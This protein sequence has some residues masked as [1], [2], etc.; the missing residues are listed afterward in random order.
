MSSRMNKSTRDVVVILTVKQSQ[1]TKCLPVLPL[2]IGDG[3]LTQNDG[4]SLVFKETIPSHVTPPTQ[5]EVTEKIFKV[6]NEKLSLL[7]QSKAKK[8]LAFG[9]VPSNTDLKDSR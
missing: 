8:P 6:L 5:A 9:P 2:Q 4:E 1:L 7:P 3:L